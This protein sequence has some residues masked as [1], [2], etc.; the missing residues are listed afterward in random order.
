MV[1]VP[2]SQLAVLQTTTQPARSLR[3]WHYHLA[4]ANWQ[5]IR[6][7]ASKQLVRGLEL[8]M[9]DQGKREQ[10]YNCDKAKMKRM[11]FRHTMASR[12]T[13][14]FDK[15]LMDL[16][17]IQES[18]MEGYTMY[19]HLM[20]EGSRYQ[21]VYGQ[22]T[23]EETVNNLK[24]FREMVRAKHH[25]VVKPFHSDQG[26]KFTNQAVAKMCAGET[27]QI[28]SHPHPPE[29]VC[30]IEKAH[31]ALMDNARSVLFSCDLPGMLWGEAARYVA[32]TINRTSTKGN[33][34]KVTPH[35]KMFGSKPSVRHLRPFGCLAI[36]LVDKVYRKDKLTVKGTPSLMIGYAAQTKGYRLLDLTTGVISEHRH[37][38]VKF[39]EETTVDRWNVE[40]LLN[41]VYRMRRSPSVDSM[42][43]PLV[44]LSVVE[45][46][47]THEEQDNER[48][49]GNERNN[50]A[51]IDDR[52]QEENDLPQA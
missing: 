24:C 48:L 44:P 7:M 10:C 14:P 51:N 52:M 39:Y 35:E 22:K 8:S 11:S 6:E 50:E 25:A 3:L 13:N 32:E 43:L 18:T 2:S 17:F 42:K 4:H 45:V 5:V 28:F 19:L 9:E 20:D 1:E 40:K 27:I 34:E 31:G 37:E 16:S 12:A 15:V 47:D 46:Q 21:W 29:E 41:E 36:R 33:A 23:K 49:S 30:L 38:N 26:T